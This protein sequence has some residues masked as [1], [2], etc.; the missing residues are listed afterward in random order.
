[1]G[2]AVKELLDIEEISLDSLSG[3]VVAIDSFN[4]LYQ[5][6]TTIR[7]ADGTPLMDSEGNVTSHL[8]GLFSRTANFLEKKIKPVFV[9]DGQAPKLKADERQRRKELKQDAQK[10]YE[11]AKDRGDIEGMKKYASRTSRLTSEMVAES[12]AL[13]KAFGCPIVQAPSEG[14]AQ[15]AYMARKGDVYAAVSQDFD[16]LLYGAPKLIRNLSIAG[17]RKKTAKLGYVTVRPE[18]II[19][20]NNLNKLGIDND[21][22]IALAMLVGTDYNYGGIKGIGPKKAIALVKKHGKEFDSLFKE[23]EW[24]KHF[25]FGWNEVYYL[26]KQMPMTDDY[27][28]EFSK[29]DLAGIKSLLCDKHGFS[30]ERTDK[31]LEKLGDQG[32]KGLGD[33][34]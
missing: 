21:Q 15:A 6:L 29:P 33:F 9:F 11:V 19:L 31:Q 25:D 4:L 8:A 17:K 12:K 22:L 1:M 26:I 10:E 16:S 14:E 2:L 32:Q 24:E 23:A 13:I 5:F 34:F 18:Q 27:S 30:V 28:L 20:S 3:K 7:Q